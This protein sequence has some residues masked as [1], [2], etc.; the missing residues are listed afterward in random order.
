[1][2]IKCPQCHTENSDTSR[3]CSECG[4][5]LYRKGQIGVSGPTDEI[6]VSCTKTLETPKEELTTGYTFAG[7]YKVIEELELIS[8]A[9]QSEPL[10]HNFSYFQL[11]L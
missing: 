10:N 7:R 11:A 5:K 6:S 1:M 2:G 8:V 4:T 3:F 9:F